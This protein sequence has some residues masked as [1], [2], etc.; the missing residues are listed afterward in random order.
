MEGV[1]QEGQAI[2]RIGGYDVI[3]AVKVFLHPLMALLR[4]SHSAAFEMMWL[5]IYR[6]ELAWKI[7]FLIML[8]SFWS[9]YNTACS[10]ENSF[11]EITGLII[12]TGSP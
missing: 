4:E 7:I 3:A 1:H 12:A 9:Q 8:F 11:I 10:N 2:R 5:D 6:Y